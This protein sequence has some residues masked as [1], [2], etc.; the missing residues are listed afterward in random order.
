[1]LHN[2]NNNIVAL[3]TTE[4]HSRITLHGHSYSQRR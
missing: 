1:V 2:L 3:Y 4:V